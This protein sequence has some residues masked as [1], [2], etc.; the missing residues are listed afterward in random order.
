MGRINSTRDAPHEGSH[1]TRTAAAKFDTYAISTLASSKAIV[2]D[3]ILV[4]D[5][6]RERIELLFEFHG[7]SFSTH[8]VLLSHWIPVSKMRRFENEREA[9]RTCFASSERLCQ[10][11]TA[12]LG[13][14]FASCMYSANEFMRL[15]GGLITGAGN[16]RR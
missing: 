15:G 9:L 11:A 2:A 5:G 13:F 1:R 12:S 6:F 16:G 14:F 10:S 3:D 8:G 7:H 4:G